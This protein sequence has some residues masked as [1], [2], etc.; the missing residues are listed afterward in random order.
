MHFLTLMRKIGTNDK[1]C[2][3]ENSK[4]HNEVLTTV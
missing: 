4:F 2:K 1:I 3:L